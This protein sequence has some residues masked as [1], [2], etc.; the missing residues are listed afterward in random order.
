M[1]EEKMISKP[2]I[3]KIH[4]LKNALGWGDDKYRAYLMERGGGFASSSKHLSHAEAGELIEAMEREAEA[5]G[6]W[7]RRGEPACSPKKYDSLGN[8]PGMASPKQLRLIEALWAEVSFHKDAAK[9]AHALNWFIFRIL[10]KSGGGQE[11]IW[12]E[13]K[14][15]QKI[16]KAIERM[17]NEEVQN[18]RR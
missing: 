11:L 8:R 18:L 7:K 4:A 13:R 15:V 2:Q 16:I 17:K 5:R 14:D 6:M 1:R 9:R 10:K 3:K 12:I